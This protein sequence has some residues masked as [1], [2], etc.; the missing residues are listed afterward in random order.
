MAG[1]LQLEYATLVGSGQLKFPLRLTGL[2]AGGPVVIYASSNLR[3][4]QA[5]FTNPPT[6]GPLQYLEEDRAGQPGR[7][8]RASESR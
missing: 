8:Y 3:D 7:Y 5:V 6:I 2:T 4:W 1:P